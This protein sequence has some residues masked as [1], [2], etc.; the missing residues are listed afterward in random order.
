MRLPRM[1]SRRVLATFAGLLLLGA[2]GCARATLDIQSDT[3]WG[4]R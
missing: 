3:C 2:G 1:T 4:A